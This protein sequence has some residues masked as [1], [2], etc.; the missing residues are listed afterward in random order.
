MVDKK[1]QSIDGFVPRG[2]LGGKPRRKSYGGAPVLTP[3]APAKK[4]VKSKSIE[5]EIDSIA[6]KKELQDSLKDLDVQR[7]DDFTDLEQQPKKPRRTKNIDK[8]QLKLDRKNK[9][10]ARKGKKKLNKKQFRVR[11]FFKRLLILILLAVLG[12]GGYFAYNAIKATGSIFDGSIFGFLHEQELMRDK[13]GRTNILVFGTE[14]EDHDGSHLTDSIILISLNQDDSSVYMISLPR[15]LYVEHVYAD[16]VT[17]TRGKINE[18]YYYGMLQSVNKNG[19]EDEKRDDKAGAAELKRAV[20]DVTGLDVQYYIHLSWDSVR[21]VTNALGGI[22]VTI[23]SD[24]PRGLYDPSCG[25]KY[26]Q[27]ETAHLNGEQALALA[28]AR[29]AFGG[30]GFSSSNFVRERNQQAILRGMQQKALANGTL[31]NS[32]T[33]VDLMNA[34]GD[35][36]STD[37][38]TS[39]VRT[40]ARVAKNMNAEEITTVPLFD[41]E[42]NIAYVTTAMMNDIS[43]VV[44]MAGLNDFSEIRQYIRSIIVLAEGWEKERAVIDVLNGSGVSGLAA[45]KARQVQESGFQVGAIDTAPTDDYVGVTIYK[46]NNDNPATAKKLAEVYS[47]NVKDIAQ[48]NGAITPS[49]GADFIIIFGQ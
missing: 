16:G 8:L 42:N 38:Q 21:Q 20:T 32:Q 49:D 27:G 46:L 5:A 22:E 34:L 10:R 47:V 30:Y 3:R 24:D 15:D 25:V 1:R 18:I 7:D 31:A 13:N 33:V 11:R 37:F 28:R 35:T 45:A 40:L 23:E 29:G 39:E 36:L 14:P 26:A 43:Y 4:Q 12:Y 2:Q 48:A 9:K 41:P 19:Y 6:L 17:R 44:S